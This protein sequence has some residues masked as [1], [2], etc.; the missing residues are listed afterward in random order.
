MSR[1]V[2]VWYTNA[3]ACTPVA[4]SVPDTAVADYQ[5]T[6][7]QVRWHVTT[8]THEMRWPKSPS[9]QMLAGLPRELTYL[10]QSVTMRKTGL[11]CG[12]GRSFFILVY[13]PPPPPR[14]FV[15]RLAIIRWPLVSHVPRQPAPR[16]ALAFDIGHSTNKSRRG[17][18]PRSVRTASSDG[19]FRQR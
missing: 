19:P 13:H 14:F 7:R 5:R 11:P 15:L 6:S 18:G 17:D 3:I 16:I 4:N 8:A 12:A 10:P 1:S 9:R 2:T